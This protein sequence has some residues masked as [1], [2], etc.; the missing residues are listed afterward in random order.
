MRKK[1]PTYFRGTPDQEAGVPTGLSRYPQ[2]Q[3]RHEAADA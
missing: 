1:R 2:G 3:V